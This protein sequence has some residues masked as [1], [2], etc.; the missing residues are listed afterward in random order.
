MTLITFSLDLFGK[1]LNFFTEKMYFN[2]AMIS[3]N[4]ILDK[5]LS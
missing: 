1:E 3:L 4:E 2:K 5:I